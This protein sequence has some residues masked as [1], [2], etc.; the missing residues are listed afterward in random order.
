[1][2]AVSDS[3]AADETDEL[4]IDAVTKNG[5]LSESE[6][7]VANIKLGKQGTDLKFKLDTGAQVN[8]IPL[9]VFHQLKTTCKLQ[10]QPTSRTLTGY[11]GQPLVVKGMCKMHCAYK[12]CSM[13]LDFYVVNTK[14]PP[15]L[16]LNA[17]LDL[18]LIKL[19]LSINAPVDQKSIREEFS[20]VFKGIGLFP[21]EC[22]I[23]LDPSATPVVCPPRKVPIALRSRLQKEL[24]HMEDTEIIAKVTEPSEWVNAL[25]VVEKPRTGKLRVCLDPEPE[26]SYQKTALPI[27]NAGGCDSKADRC[28][29]LQCVRCMF[30]I[31]GHQT[32]H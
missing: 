19:V 8:V 14:A 32:H 24:Q 27:T 13:M 10:L 18:D 1:M 7:A 15:V 4:F 30:R 2:H 22:T 6:Q 11:G 25:E 31:L 9:S 12:D 16:G 26:Q 23:H 17:C 5:H 29:A 20:D 3:H 21:G 28:K